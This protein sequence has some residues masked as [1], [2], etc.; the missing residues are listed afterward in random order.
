MSEMDLHDQREDE[1][2]LDLDEQ[3]DL[4]AEAPEGDAAEQRLPAVEDE[5]SGPGRTTLELGVEADPADVVEQDAAV[6]TGDDDYR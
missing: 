6:G 1:T 5:P 4:A 3:E 2:P